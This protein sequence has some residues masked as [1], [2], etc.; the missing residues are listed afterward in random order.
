MSSNSPLPGETHV[1]HLSAARGITPYLPLKDHKITFN[2]PLEAIVKMDVTRGNGNAAESTHHEAHEGGSGVGGLNQ[3]DPHSHS[4]ASVSSMMAAGALQQQQNTPKPNIHPLPLKL[5]VMQ[6]VIPDDP[7]NSPQNLRLGEVVL[8]LAEYVGK[9]KVERRFLLK[10]SRVNAML[11]KKAR[12]IMA[13]TTSSRSD[14]NGKEPGM[15]ALLSVEALEGADGDVEGEVDSKSPGLLER[16]KDRIA[17]VLPGDTGDTFAESE[18]QAARV[19]E[20]QVQPMVHVGN[21]FA[22]PYALPSESKSESEV[23]SEVEVNPRRPQRRMTE[24]ELGRKQWKVEMKSKRREERGKKLM[25]NLSES[26]DDSAFESAD[27]GLEDD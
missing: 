16:E 14:A 1:R 17:Q 5:V 7:S 11:K 13:R 21:H 9:G 3:N 18:A 2:F 20:Q 6:K 24:E 23:A 25:L 8:N 19:W 15:A 26:E 27:D 4:S 22:D 12:V 10:K